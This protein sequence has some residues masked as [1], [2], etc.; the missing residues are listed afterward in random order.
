VLLSQVISGLPVLSVEGSA[1]VEVERVEHDSRRA[2][3]GVL[4]ACVAGA[5]VDGHR[6]AAAAVQAGSPALLVERPLDVPGATQVVVA[7]SRAALAGTAAAVAG[8][9][10]RDLTVIGVTGT[11]GKTTT[12]WLLRS[13]FEHAGRP[14]AVLGTLRPPGQEGGPPT[15]PDA[16][17]LQR[18]LA[19]R[20][21]E[22]T[23]VVAMEVSSH[24]LVAHRVDGT[25]FAAAVFTNLTPDHLDYHQTM[26]AYFEAKAR[27]FTPGLAERGIVNLDDPQ[28]RVLHTRAAIPTTGYG[29]ADAGD[30][31]VTAS[32]STFRWRGQPVQLALGARFN[33]A[34][35]LAAAET[36][37][38][39]GVDEA[40]ISAGL[41]RPLAV[42]G[43]FEAIDE[44]QPF[45]VV[46]DYAHTPDGLD[47]VLAAARDVAAGAAVHVVFGCG[48]DRDV[49]KRPLMGAVA[50]RGA[51]RVIITADNSRHEDTRAIIAAVREG[52]NH[53]TNAIASAVVVEPDRDAAIAGALAAARPG[54]VVVIAG[55]GHETTQTIGDTVT[56]FD[57]REVAR[58]HLRDLVGRG[59]AALSNGSG[60]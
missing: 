48:G 34:N 27:L 35:A 38:A 26:E 28:G 51:D 32:G 44:G 39:L 37:R 40:T 47:Q 58:R 43:R 49:T 60:S 7:D 6:F 41:S 55:K 59:R 22:G 52:T 5:R 25:R 2:G 3:P 36:A 33:V 56:D 9:P 30:L 42:P 23:S 18:W 13:I 17:D 57:D 14:S 53:A 31:H 20:R 46:V 12:T 10:S 19:E 16:P 54:D 50:A 1:D 15:T 11:N 21:D 4:F 8:H 29:L 45:R 24:A